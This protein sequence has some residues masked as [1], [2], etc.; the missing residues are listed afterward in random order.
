[1]VKI[2][3]RA[4]LVAAIWACPVAAHDY[5][6]PRFLAQ[7]S[8][9]FLD[10]LSARYLHSHPQQFIFA[11]PFQ[12]GQMRVT[13]LGLTLQNCPA[14]TVRL[15]GTVSGQANLP[16]IANLSIGGFTQVIEGDWE[17]MAALEFVGKELHLRLEPSSLQFHLTQ[18]LALQVPREWTAALGDL[19]AGSA[20]KLTIPIPGA[21]SKELVESGIFRSDE[22]NSWKVL[23]SSTGNRRTSFLAVIGPF[24]AGPGAGPP[25]DPR[26][27][28]GDDF[29]LCLSPEAVNRGLK[30]Q[31]E[32]LLPIRQPVP[33]IYR[34]G[35]QIF[36]FTLQ[37]TVLEITELQL[38]YI[39][40][41]GQGL[42]SIDKIATAVHWNIGPLSG[43]EPALEARGRAR[44]SGE[45]RPLNLTATTDITD[46]RFLS[47]RILER[48]TEEQEHLRQQIV[49][50][51]KKLQL[52]LPL[53]ARLPV[54]DL[55]EG[56]ALELLG[57]DCLPQELLLRGKLTN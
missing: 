19:L 12:A 33:E 18:P 25:S 43:V 5:T 45:G 2:L 20:P 24:D 50:G 32:R 4:F 1:M 13:R 37:L 39:S 26:L 51:L 44:I 52:H 16:Q 15:F 35:P 34:S 8:E 11:L 56:A 47:P 9:L 21:Y 36:L 10:R 53:A 7:L 23:T 3:A 31:T 28:E 41:A 49:E 27:R 22:L 14:N 54:P 42:L 55:G 48:P 57:V 29:V 40:A 30:A 17:C 6:H 46:L 38:S